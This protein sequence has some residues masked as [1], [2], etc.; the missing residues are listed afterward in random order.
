MT[1]SYANRGG[2]KGYQVRVTRNGQQY[3]KFFSSKT[4]GAKKLAQDYERQLLDLLGPATSG[5][6][7]KRP[8]RTNTGIRYI[9]ETTGK[10]GTAC[11]RVTF[12]EETGHWASRDVSIDQ[13]G[14]TK[15]LRIAKQIHKDRH[16]PADKEAKQRAISPT[17]VRR[18]LEDE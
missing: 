9:T 3:T 13:H 16:V 11:F 7:K 6:G 12:R 18:L 14:R 2:S 8:V 5:K 17:T 1:I 4:K 10:Y 15:A